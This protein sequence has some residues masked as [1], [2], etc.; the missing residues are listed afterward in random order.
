MRYRIFLLFHSFLCSLSFCGI[1]NK[2]PWYYYNWSKPQLMHE[3][4]SNQMSDKCFDTFTWLT[5]NIYEHDQN[6]YIRGNIHQAREDHSK[7]SIV[8]TRCSCINY[9]QL[10]ALGVVDANYVDFD[11]LYDIHLNYY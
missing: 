1:K 2:T 11:N 5:K 10:K 8:Y 6:I 7:S 3:L 4:I 9:Y